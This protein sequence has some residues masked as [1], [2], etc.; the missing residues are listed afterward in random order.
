MRKIFLYAYWE[1]WGFFFL[2]FKTASRMKLFDWSRLYHVS[3]WWEDNEETVL[4]K[5]RV[6]MYVCMYICMYVCMYV[7]MGSGALSKR[8]E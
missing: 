3:L 4:P 2:P 7:C 5:E 1:N 8:K 6:Y